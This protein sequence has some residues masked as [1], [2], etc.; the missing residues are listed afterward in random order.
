MRVPTVRALTLLGAATVLT[1]LVGAALPSIAYADIAPPAVETS[2]TLVVT[3]SRASGA[4]VK[5]GPQVWRSFGAVATMRLTDD[6]GAPVPGAPVTLQVLDRGAIG[7]LVI[8]AATAVTDADGTVRIAINPWS[9][10]TYRMAYAGS[11]GR[12]APSR[13]AAVLV[14]PATPG[15]RVGSP[16]GSPQ[17]TAIGTPLGHGAGTG[18]DAVITS[19]PNAVWASMV[20]Y[21]WRPGCP[22]GRSQLAYI[23]VNYW[24]F[25]GNRYR[26]ELVVAKTRAAAFARA[27]TALYDA[28][29]PI[30]SMVR[31][32]RWGRSPHGWPGADDYSSMAHDNTYAFNCRYVV[33]AEGRHLLSPHAYGIA[34]DIN[35]WENPDAA[36]NGTHPDSWFF[37][38]RVAWYGGEILKG[39]TVVRIMRAAGFGWGGTSIGDLQHFDPT[40]L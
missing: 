2:S 37:H 13:S 25:D 3:G 8:N 28:H 38:H 7:T 26:G 22:V 5:P 30:R 16:V 29:F 27:F 39:S 12:L 31:P 32:D 33:G 10:V 35:T 4:A 11:S 9:P 40:L 6:T 18:A 34:V 20:G 23:L 36:A 14:T 17:P 15:A 19:I 21:T 1:S 24:G